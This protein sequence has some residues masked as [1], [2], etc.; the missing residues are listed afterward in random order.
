MP[1]F[2][3]PALRTPSAPPARVGAPPPAAGEIFFG[4]SVTFSENRYFSFR[5]VLY[6]VGVNTLF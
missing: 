6:A 2:R 5:F 4:M 1:M 3:G